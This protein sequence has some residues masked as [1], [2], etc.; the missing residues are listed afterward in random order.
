MLISYLLYYLGVSQPRTHIINAMLFILC[1]AFLGIYLFVPQKIE[2]KTFVYYNKP[3]QEWKEATKYILDNADKNSVIIIDKNIMFYDYYFQRFHKDSN[4]A[5]IIKDTYFFFDPNESTG[6]KI[7]NLK[8]RYKK[9]KKIYIF[10]PAMLK[11][12]E[13]Q[14]EIMKK[15]KLGKVPCPHLERK[16]FIGVSLYVCY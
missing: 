8:K 6:K 9:I 15:A 13:M 4:K 5:K 3:K 10:S 16:D 7:R 11:T 12:K 1:A 14:Y 2:N